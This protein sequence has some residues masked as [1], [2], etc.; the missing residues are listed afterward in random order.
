MTCRDVQPLLAYGSLGVLDDDESMRLDAHLESC[1]ACR[2]RA[3]GL[4][5]A[6]APLAAPLSEEDA[7]TAAL[8]SGVVDRL[9]EGD[10]GPKPALDGAVD[11]D[12]A[13]DVA[14]ALACTFCRDGVRRP[15][16]VYCAS[17]LAPHHGDCFVSHGRCSAAGCEETRTVRPLA[18]RPPPRS[19]V[20]RRRLLALLLAGGAAVGAAALAADLRLGPF[21][22]E[23]ELSAGPSGGA[24]GAAP[25]VTFGSPPADTFEGEVVYPPAYDPTPAVADD[26]A[27]TEA[28]SPGGGRRDA[29][30]PGGRYRGV[31]VIESR[32]VGVWDP[33]DVGSASEAGAAGHLASIEAE[34]VEVGDEFTVWRGERLIGRLAVRWLAA[35]WPDRATCAVLEVTDGARVQAGDRVLLADEA[36]PLGPSARPRPL[37]V[38]A[39][40]L[41]RH[42]RWEY[43]YL[44]SA[45]ER[46]RTF[47]FQAYLTS[48]DPDFVQ[49]SSPNLDPLEAPPASAEAYDV[50]V[51]GEHEAG[52]EPAGLA[53]WVRS[54][55]GLVLVPGAGGV[56]ATLGPVCEELSPVTDGPDGGAAARG[57]RTVDAGHGAVASLARR[58]PRRLPELLTARPGE[59]REG[60]RVLADLG[61]GFPLVAT[62]A[63]G[64]GRVVYVGA[65]DTW[66]WRSPEPEVHRRF[67]VDLIRWAAGEGAAAA[68]PAAAEQPAV[69]APAPEPAAAGADLPDLPDVSVFRVRCSEC[70]G[71][72]HRAVLSPDGRAA[73][74]PREGGL[75]VHYDG[76]VV[77]VV[78][79]V[80][81]DAPLAW[82]PDARRLAF[83]E[84][85][86]ARLEVLE[87]P[88]TPGGD[89]VRRPLI[90]GDG[91]G[92]VVELRWT[93]GGV[94]AREA[95]RLLRLD[96][97]TDAVTW[98]LERDGVIDL[99]LPSSGGDAV[100]YGHEEGIFLDDDLAAGGV[101][102]VSEL[103]A[104]GVSAAAWAPRAERLLLGTDHELP[105]GSRT[106]LAGAYLLSLAPA[107]GLELLAHG[108]P[109]WAGFSPGGERVAFRLDGALAVGPAAGASEPVWRTV[110]RLAGRRGAAAAVA[111][112]PGGERLAAAAGAVELQVLSPGGAVER[113]ALAVPGEACF[114]SA[115]VWCDGGL[116]AA[117]FAASGPATEWLEGSVAGRGGGEPRRREGRF[118]I[119]GDRVRVDDGDDERVFRLEAVHLFRLEAVHPFRQ[120]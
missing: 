95:R 25:V 65:E 66:R 68:A 107:G 120:R 114:V 57:I 34:D 47:G 71:G 31:R 14:I 74:V 61:E 59:A 118:R 7:R 11:V 6:L 113:R 49:E 83:C 1:P 117:A 28:A 26:G 99:F 20:P 62:W 92:Q 2:D 56:A 18:D 37:P 23:D 10:S 90:P 81:P 8:W 109:T 102:R 85:P 88:A 105:D 78:A 116:A 19:P 40:Y 32:V 3:D 35:I 94:F 60:A 96:P 5:A 115:P 104:A 103:A 80:S 100:V 69:P 58:D 16:A 21:G 41:E 89:L 91:L 4:D 64:A 44:K 36:G 86:G 63:V 30:R 45:L 112:E 119:E 73:V 98:S 111:W 9:A 29:A 17:C 38:R 72:A 24:G 51:L 101:R 84:R 48:A 12:V 39:F 50:V 97:E 54:G 42:P 53:D 108:Q 13:A 75:E 93:P 87:L 79:R 52:Q 67:W 110:S 55:G 22:P 46:E 76:R 82:A 77:F 70:P 106:L 43:R 27:G 15:E 33:D